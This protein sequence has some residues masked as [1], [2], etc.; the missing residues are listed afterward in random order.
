MF[1][2]LFVATLSVLVFALAIMAA[3]AEAAASQ[4][5][6]VTEMKA[7]EKRVKKLRHGYIKY[8]GNK[9]FYYW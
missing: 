3:P 8:D 7:D 9:V 6:D 2:R 4:S 1:S 5:A